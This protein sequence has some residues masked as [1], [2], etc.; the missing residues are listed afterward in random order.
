MSS[1]VKMFEALKKNNIL[2][3]PPLWEPQRYQIRP[4][5][6]KNPNTK[7]V[8]ITI[9]LQTKVRVLQQMKWK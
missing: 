4:S 5:V 8:K 6:Y 7:A 9:R 1:S 2:P 3:R